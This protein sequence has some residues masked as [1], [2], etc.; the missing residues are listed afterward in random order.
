MRVQVFVNAQGQV[1]P[2]STRLTP[3][4]SNASFNQQVLDN[5]ATW[6]FRPA[7]QNNA[8]VGAWFTYDIGM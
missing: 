6:R 5:A 8:P 2:D 1:V 7:R 4:T 3:P